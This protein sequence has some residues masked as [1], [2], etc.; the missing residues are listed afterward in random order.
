MGSPD[1]QPQAKP[2][3]PG[4]EKRPCERCLDPNCSILG[5]VG[6][7]S[8][9]AKWTTSSEGGSKTGDI[10]VGGSIWRALRALRAGPF[11]IRSIHKPSDCVTSCERPVLVWAV[12]L[13]W[14]LGRLA[15]PSL[16]NSLRPAVVAHVRTACQ[17]SQCLGAH[18]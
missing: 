17:S 5:K 12:W 14:W 18:C 8:E 7:A 11:I 10:A 15:K 3:W 13:V 2:S 1:Y 16:A 6:S 4:Q 9:G